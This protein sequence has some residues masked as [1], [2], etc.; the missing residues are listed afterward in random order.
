MKTSVV[1]VNYR[2]A[3]LTVDAVNS[4]LEEPEAAEIIVVDNGSD[5]G[6]IELLSQL[7][8]K[9]DRVRFVRSHENL[10]F[11]RANNLG[12]R[13]ATEEFVFLL[14]SDATFI[15]GCLEALAVQ[16]N[17]LSSPGVLAPAVLRAD[18]DELQA[19]AHGRFPTARSTLRLTTRCTGDASLEPDWVS[20][21]AMLLGRE[22]FL[23]VGGFDDDIFMYFEDVLLCWKLR[24]KGLQAHRHLGGS[25]RHLG[26][27]SN[28]A[29]FHRNRAYDHAQDLM[30][31]KLS[32]PLAGRMLVKLVRAPYRWSGSTRLPSSSKSDVKEPAH[33][34]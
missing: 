1:I 3:L 34:Y 5:D 31:K 10:G 4:A 6:S 25:V 12:V 24:A 8:S 7:F 11:G 19:D 26:G 33:D 20:G 22:D 18:S 15:P 14:N 32:Q 28:H 21:C 30:L 29:R 13:L 2:T 23:G 27:G 16:W 17:Q 9:D